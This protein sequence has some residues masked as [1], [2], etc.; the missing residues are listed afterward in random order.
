MNTVSNAYARWTAYAALLAITV[1]FLSFI[2][3]IAIAPQAFPGIA[4]SITPATIEANALAASLD[5]TLQVLYGT[6]LIALAVLLSYYHASP[7]TNLLRFALIAGIIGGAG[8]VIAGAISQ[9]KVFLSV[10]I[11]P[12]QSREMATAMGMADHAAVNMALEV[13]AGGMRSAGSYAFGWALILW[14]IYA[15]RARRFPAALNWIG[16]AAGISFALTNWIGPF[17]GPLA[18]VGMLI[19][20]IWLGIYLLRRPATLA[21]PAAEPQ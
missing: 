16:I 4:D 17:A 3:A 15:L 11:T 7:L 20:H 21:N 18:F 2:Y 14:G 13:V 1:L 19:W 9:E 8:F 10:F 6:A 12:E 5:S